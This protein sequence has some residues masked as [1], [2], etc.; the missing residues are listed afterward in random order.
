M[1]RRVGGQQGPQ[2]SLGI[3]RPAPDGAIRQAL[4]VALGTIG[5]GWLATGL[6][7]AEPAGGSPNEQVIAVELKQLSDPTIL[8]RRAWLETE[9]NKYKDGTHD[10]EETLGG[11]WAWR[12]STN[13]DWAVRLKVPYE[14]HIAG[15]A[16]GDSD[17][18]G[19]GDIKL[20]TGTALRLSDSWRVGGGL[21]LRMPTAE[22][23][24]GD[25]D[26][27]LQEFG[28]VAWDAT[29][30]LT[31]SPSVEYNESLAEES[32]GAQQHY[33]EAFFPATFLLP[34]RW[35]VTPKYE[36]KVDFKNDNY[37]THSSK[38]SLAKQLH[39][40]PLGFSLSIKKSFDGGDKEFQVNF[41]I[42]WHFR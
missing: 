26:W 6:W 31:L 33:V 41:V 7:A 30:W 28:A 2:G 37:V 17:D 25:K 42:T 39:K 18:Q 3:E 22:D 27:R 11:L 8:K 13:Q 21:E 29:R 16:A 36:A 34:H 32:G 38:L 4:V 9:W 23:D 19:L 15:D 24:L 20:A 1:E 12:V 10:M 14:W 35:S 5:A 40:L